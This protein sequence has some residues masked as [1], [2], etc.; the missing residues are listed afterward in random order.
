[1]KRCPVKSKP[2]WTV[3]VGAEPEAKVCNKPALENGYCADHQV[4]ARIKQGAKEMKDAVT[5]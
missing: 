1:M 4:F 3:G 5:N 2:V